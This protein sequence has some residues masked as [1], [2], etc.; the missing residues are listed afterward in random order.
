MKC[1]EFK[2]YYINSQLYIFN[3]DFPFLILKSVNFTIRF[4]KIKE[5]KIEIEIEITANLR[6]MLLESLVIVSQL[7]Q[8][9]S[10]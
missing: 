1:T 10:I 7:S 6:D 3:V 2:G 5:L 4:Q 9:I 8:L